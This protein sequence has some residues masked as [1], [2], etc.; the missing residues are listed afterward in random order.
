MIR[1]AIAGYGNLG[2]GCELALQK[3]P[4]M[5]L[6]AVFS[7]RDPSSVKTIDPQIPVYRLEDAAS[8]RDEVDV[9]IIFNA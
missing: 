5:K 3:N 9:L 1:I 2:R 8:H 7:R 6:T 4:D